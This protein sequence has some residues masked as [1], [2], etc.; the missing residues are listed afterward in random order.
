MP[1]DAVTNPHGGK[2]GVAEGGHVVKPIVSLIDSFVAAGSTVVATRDYHPHDHVSFL[3]QGGPFPAHCVQ[4]SP[5]SK[6]LPA[7]AA[8]LAAG[9][10]VLGGDKVR[11][12]VRCEQRGCRVNR[13]VL[14][15]HC[16][17]HG[18]RMVAWPPID[19][20]VVRAH[21]LAA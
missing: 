11:V 8:A 14:A 17:H 6:F 12:A 9:V 7:I 1:Q 20:Q 10:R 13:E 15:P 2:F 4:G 3:S 21:G 19:S 18:C 16:A 5:G